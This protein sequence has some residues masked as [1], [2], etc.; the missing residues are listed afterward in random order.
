MSQ[1]PPPDQRVGWTAAHMRLLTAIGEEFSGTRPFAGLRIG[2]SNHLEPKT[3]VLL[4]TLQ[5]GGADLVAAGN[6]G[7]TQ[8]DVVEYLSDTGI[9][10]RGSSSD[11]TAA[12][13]A[14]LDSI[15]AEAPDLL[16][17][18]GADLTARA[19]DADLDVL[20]G[21][22]ETTSGHFR[23]VDE[24]ASEVRFPVIVINDSP[25]K[26]LAENKHAVGQSV[27]E[28]FCRHTN[29]MPQ[30]KTVLVVGYGWCGR[31]IAHYFRSNGASVVV[32]ELDEIKRLEAFLDGFI[33]GTTEE[34][35]ARATVVITATGRPSVFGERELSVVPSGALLA[36]AG[37][38]PNEIDVD[39]LDRISDDRSQLG[40]DLERHRL[41]DGRVIDLIARGQMMNLKGTAPK[42]NSIESMDL[43]FA[44]QA[45]SL[46]RLATQREGLSLGAQPVPDDINRSLANAFVTTYRG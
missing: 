37:H 43:G 28:S 40:S 10:A 42:G 26:A 14:V 34:L 31:G 5:R 22:E 1:L 46:E 32:A 38:F 7:T 3:A 6:L 13:A 2:V 21:T 8:D 29:L 17:D 41:Q 45:R 16:L 20:G 23:L 27:Y 25:L 35:A 12:H 44:M 30:G 24:L 39:A 15:V 4:E 9:D 33:V 19:C 36:N 11:D 18:N